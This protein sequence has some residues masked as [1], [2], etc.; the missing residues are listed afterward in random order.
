M[1][2][3]LRAPDHIDT[4]IQLPSSKSISNRVLIMNQLSGS[5][6]QLDNLSDC[7]DT[8]VMLKAL[9]NRS[10]ITDIH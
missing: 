5:K 10:E 4:V 1:H 6:I 3:T 8:R 2:Y 7:D 9:N